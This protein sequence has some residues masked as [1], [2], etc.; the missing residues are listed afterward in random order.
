MITR[1]VTRGD[2]LAADADA[3]VVADLA[4]VSIEF[5]VYARDLAFVAEGKPVVVAGADGRQAEGRVTYVGP[6]LDPATGAARVVASLENKD[7][8]WH[9]GDFAS[10][11]LEAD[12]QPADLMVPEEAVQTLE[13]RTVVFVPVPEGFERRPVTVGRTDGRNAEVLSG[14]KP[15]EAVASVNAFIL[16][17]EA[18]K[19]EAGHED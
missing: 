17:A 4:Q 16:K 19:D 2:R 12:A 10:G 9:P 6:A 18:G 1:S 7:G 13:G 14:L 15:G 11:T 5:P 3:Y 8:G